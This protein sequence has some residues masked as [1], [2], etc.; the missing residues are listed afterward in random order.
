M[1]AV[2]RQ[3]EDI[4]ETIA[5]EV[6]NDVSV[7]DVKYEGP[8]LVVYTRDPKRFAGD[9]DLIRRL[10]SQLRK[11]I[12]VRPDPDVLSRPG[13]A[14]DRIREIIPDEA[15]VTDLDFHADTGEV[16]IEAEK[17]GMV[18]GRHGSTLR[19][20]TQE[21][22]WTPEVVRTPPIESST[23]SNVRNFLKQE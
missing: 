1:S 10:A 12:T 18:I 23:V 15:G 11:R 13:E 16:V 5:S 4:K 6:P 3:L 17:P 22:G 21:V 7:S 9:G 19:E 20:I 8:E 14:R 2:E